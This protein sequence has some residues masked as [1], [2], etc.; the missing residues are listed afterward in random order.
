MGRNAEG[1]DDQIDQQRRDA[2][3]D[4]ANRQAIAVVRPWPSS[5]VCLIWLSV[6]VP[7]T[8]DT[9]EPMQQNTP[10]NDD[11]SETIAMVLVPGISRA[12]RGPTAAQIIR[13]REIAVGEPG[14]SGLCPP[15]AG[16]GV[17][18]S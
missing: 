12:R 7:S 16:G 6:I 9:I 3:Y 13:R 14:C 17:V 11:T 10:A 1:R 8:T 4:A 18:Q 15:A 5:R 2:D